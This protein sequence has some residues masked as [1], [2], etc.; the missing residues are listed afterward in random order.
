MTCGL[1]EEHVDEVVTITD[2]EIAAACLLLLE[3]AKQPVEGTGAA[4][5]AAVLN[6]TLDVSGEIVVPVLSGGN[7]DMRLL[8]TVLTHELTARKQ[9]LGLRVRIVDEP[10][11]MAEMSGIIADHGANIRTVQHTRSDQR[12]RVDEASLEFAVDASGEGHARRVCG[13]IEDQGYAV[14][15]VN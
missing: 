13:A 7:L 9:L 8:R 15:R 12:L 1:I 11:K 14:E 5:V 4:P 3:R 2:D 6:D 10:G